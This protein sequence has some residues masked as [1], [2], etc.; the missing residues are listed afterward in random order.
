MSRPIK[1]VAIIGGTHGN[2]YTGAHLIRHWTFNPAEITRP[3]FNTSLFL[4]NPK[5]F[6]ENRRFIDED[7]NRCFGMD[8]LS[9]TGSMSYEANRAIVL[10][11]AIGPKGHPARHDF[12]IDLHTSTSNCGAM[13]ILLDDNPFNVCL[14]AYL[15]VRIPEAKI[16][17][18]PPTGG[19]QPYLGS[20]CQH[21]LTV[22]VGPIPQ[23]VLRQDIYALTQAMVA[24]ALDFAHQ[25]N[26]GAIPE[27]PDRVEIFRFQETLGYPDDGGHMGAMIHES[28]QDKDYQPLNSGDPIFRL[29]NGVEIFYEGKNTVYPV[30]INEAAYYY[31]RIAMCLTT[32][33][34]I[35]VPDFGIAEAE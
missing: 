14:A 10:N 13:I 11:Q 18:I 32:K 22:E 31:K 12:L 35:R 21:S 2:E 1:N 19:D 34:T 9:A 3:T 15:T 5:A 28:L 17:Y 6:A 4:G 29:L 23:G 20:L 26:L 30:F 25:A 7:L 27:L 33:E 16:H 24:H 8:A